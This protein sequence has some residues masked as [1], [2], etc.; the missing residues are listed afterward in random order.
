MTDDEAIGKSRAR[1]ERKRR[2]AERAVCRAE[3][4]LRK[5]EKQRRREEKLVQKLERSLKL[6][7]S[8]TPASTPVPTSSHR[9]QLTSANTV[10]Q[11]PSRSE[12]ETATAARKQKKDRLEKR[13]VQVG[14]VKK[15]TLPPPPYS[16]RQC[17]GYLGGLQ[18]GLE[19]I[20]RRGR[21]DLG[22][23]SRAGCTMSVSIFTFSEF[24]MSS[25]FNSPGYQGPTCSFVASLSS[26]LGGAALRYDTC[27]LYAMFIY[28]RISEYLQFT[29]IIKLSPW[30]RPVCTTDDERRFPHYRLTKQPILTCSSVE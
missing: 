25:L 30:H 19:V 10:L 2:K 13:K 3:K 21:V 20:Q 4:A 14:A 17:S 7:S 24:E 9:H 8:S 26:P 16:I 15:P 6:A 22:E 27:R 1:L 29:L 23:N 12:R 18:G 28:S 11:L 5:E